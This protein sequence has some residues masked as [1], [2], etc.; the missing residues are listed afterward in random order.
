VTPREK[1]SPEERGEGEATGA[2]GLDPHA[3]VSIVQQFR[4]A[5]ERGVLR[6]AG[7]SEFEGRPTRRYV[8]TLTEE[9]PRAPGRSR[10]PIARATQT[11]HVDAK[12]ALPLAMTMQR[13]ID[14]ATGPDGRQRLDQK[15]LRYEKLDPTPEN[16][17][18]LR[19]VGPP[20]G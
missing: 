4:R 3:A 13:T 12:S 18:K 2:L 5:Y 15:L 11:W 1:L 14:Q 20:R 16:L 8:A 6:D 10:G 17:R 19:F 9:G 7:P